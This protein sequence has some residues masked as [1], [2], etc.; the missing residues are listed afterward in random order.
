MFRI[1]LNASPNSLSSGDDWRKAG[2][3]D[4]GEHRADRLREQIQEYMPTAIRSIS[5][6]AV[7]PTLAH[8]LE[9]AT[10]AAEAQEKTLRIRPVLLTSYR[11]GARMLTATFAIS[12]RDSKNPFPHPAFSRWKYS[13]RGW[14]DIKEIYSPMLSTRERSRLDARLH[15][16][17][18]K[19]LAALKFFP[20]RD[21]PKSLDALR[22]YREFHRFYPVFRSVEE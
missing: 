4:P 21:R 19:M 12:E 3:A 11:D 6:T 7:A 15:G 18:A 14:N 10:K 20:S 8:C 5:E 9:L 1:T 13:S 16:G 2:A 17:A 22:S